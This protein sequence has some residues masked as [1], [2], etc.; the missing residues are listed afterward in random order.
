MT[1][2]SSITL[3]RFQPQPFIQILNFFFFLDQACLRGI[4]NV[5][6]IAATNL[7]RWDSRER[8]EQALTAT[9][10]S[11]CGEIIAA[12]KK[13]GI[14]L[15]ALAQRIARLASGWGG[16]AYISRMQL[17]LSSPYSTKI[18]NSVQVSHQ[19]KKKNPKHMCLPFLN[20]KSNLSKSIPKP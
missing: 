17:T 12:V 14:C 2:H 19:K 3:G 7:A 15:C 9:R 6:S 1:K 4:V 18:V 5:C 13:I 11:S 10:V 20:N 8:R 16:G